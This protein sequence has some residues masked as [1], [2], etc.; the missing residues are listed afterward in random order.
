MRS[1]VV[2]ISFLYFIDSAYAKCA[3]K[4]SFMLDTEILSCKV[5]YF[6]DPRYND[7]VLLK[8]KVNEEIPFGTSGPMNWEEVMK[9]EPYDDRYS[10]KGKVIPL[11]FLN[12][13]YSC[14]DARSSKTFSKGNKVFYV[15][16]L[17]CD[18]ANEICEQANHTGF[19]PPSSFYT[20]NGPGWYDPALDFNEHDVIEE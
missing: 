9:S 3:A 5:V 17:C 20:K 11:L 2:L 4:P 13:E 7:A 8:V 14:F 19:K 10:V 1:L 16:S 6:D 15:N 12:N 18:S